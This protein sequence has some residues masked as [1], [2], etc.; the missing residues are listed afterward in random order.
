M[1]TNPSGS[2]VVA[3][4]NSNGF[5]VETCLDGGVLPVDAP[6]MVPNSDLVPIVHSSPRVAPWRAAASR[7]MRLSHVR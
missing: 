6:D 3:A 5:D 4:K 2:H 7:R 1:S